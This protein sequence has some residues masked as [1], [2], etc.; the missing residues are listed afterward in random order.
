MKKIPIKN[1]EVQNELD[2]RKSEQ[3][4]HV[5]AALGFLRQGKILEKNLKGRGSIWY[6]HQ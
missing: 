1:S 3:M 4:S 2:K 6:G 5:Q